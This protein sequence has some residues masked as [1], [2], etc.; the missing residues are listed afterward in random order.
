MKTLFMFI[1]MVMFTTQEPSSEATIASNDPPPI[2]V[3][4]E[5]KSDVYRQAQADKLKYKILIM[6]MQNNLEKQLIPESDEPRY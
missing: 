1:L 2:N 3:P 4:R 6:E 5:S